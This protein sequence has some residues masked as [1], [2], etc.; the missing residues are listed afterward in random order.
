MIGLIGKKGLWNVIK[1]L[2]LVLYEAEAERDVRDALAHFESQKAQLVF[3]SED[4]VDML[5]HDIDE[6]CQETRCNVVVLPSPV[7]ANDE[8]K[9]GFAYERIRKV[10]EKAMGVD[11]LKN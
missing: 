8:I 9:K 5:K 11:I 7:I 2:G 6:L 4:V 10:V 1:P 3:I